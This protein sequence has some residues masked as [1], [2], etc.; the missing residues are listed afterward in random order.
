MSSGL[1][2]H[3]FEEHS[4]SGIIVCLIL[5]SELLKGLLWKDSL[6]IFE[7]AT[8]G[9]LELHVVA[10]PPEQRSHGDTWLADSINALLASLKRVGK[11]QARFVRGKLRTTRLDEISQ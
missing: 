6:P 10:M 4:D 8:G 9:D 5:I 3:A 11:Q 7:E 1:L 2:Q